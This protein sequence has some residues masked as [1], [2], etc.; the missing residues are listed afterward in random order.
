MPVTFEFWVVIMSLWSIS[1]FVIN[2][3]ETIDVNDNMFYR[4]EKKIV[5]YR[6]IIVSPIIIALFFSTFYEFNC[7]YNG[8]QKG[9]IKSILF[10]RFSSLTALFLQ[11]SILDVAEFYLAYNQIIVRRI[12][13]EIFYIIAFIVQVVVLIYFLQSMDRDDDEFFNNVDSVMIVNVEVEN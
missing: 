11:T 8:F 12:L 5:F 3:L 1:Y 4:D 2:V 13:F 6:Q 9:Y 7:Y 10:I